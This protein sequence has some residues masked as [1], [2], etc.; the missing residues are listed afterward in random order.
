[1]TEQMAIAQAVAAHVDLAKA[2][3]LRSRLDSHGHRMSSDAKEILW[4][5]VFAHEDAAKELVEAA[6]RG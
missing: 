3:S 6:S 4:A 5:L 2:K 1:M